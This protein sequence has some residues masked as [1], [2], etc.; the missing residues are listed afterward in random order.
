MASSGKG[1]GLESDGQGMKA[2][3]SDRKD[4]LWAVIEGGGQG[5]KAM[6]RDRRRRAMRKGTGQGWQVVGRDG[7]QWEGM[8]AVDRDWRR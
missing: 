6:G 2:M 7:K 8:A 3:G 1:Q 4:E 5:L